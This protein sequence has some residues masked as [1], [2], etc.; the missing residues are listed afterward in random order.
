MPI[1][2][3]ELL[4]G[5]QLPAQENELAKVASSLMTYGDELAIRKIA[6]MEDEAKKSKEEE[7][8]EEKGE[9]PSLSDEEKK[10]ASA[11]GLFALEGYINKLAQAGELIYGDPSIYIRKL[12]E[13][14]GAYEKVASFADGLRTGWEA[15][16]GFGKSVGHHLTHPGAFGR[17]APGEGGAALARDL[18][19]KGVAGMLPGAALGAGTGALVAD[20]SG[21]GA[22]WG[23]L[24]GGL[25]GAG[26]GMG[27]VGIRQGVQKMFGNKDKALAAAKELRGKAQTEQALKTQRAANE[28]ARQFG[29]G[30]GPTHD[31]APKVERNFGSE[32]V[33]G[34]NGERI[35]VASGSTLDLLLASRDSGIL[36]K[37]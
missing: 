34:P 35:S 11:M 22:G 20:D 8:K 12:A 23:A 33:Y 25:G 5:R 7:D 32:N 4:A 31:A 36:S 24:A 1:S 6:A 37:Y 2:P 10:E 29:P 9:H 16:K 26:L 30:S 3:Q 14:R 27:G 19:V 21:A 13:E 15:T 18:G 17:R 28:K